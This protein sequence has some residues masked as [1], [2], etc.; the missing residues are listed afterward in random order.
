MKK[1]L[2]LILLF[3]ILISTTTGVHAGGAISTNV[4]ETR[5]TQTC[6]AESLIESLLAKANAFICKVKQEKRSL[7]NREGLLSDLY[8]IIGT[9]NFC[10]EIEIWKIM[11]IN[12]MLKGVKFNLFEIEVRL[13]Y[14]EQH[15]DEL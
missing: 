8:D 5:S 3:G 12:D 10:K 15:A 7:P 9:L 13:E 4:P 1:L 2:G 6:R 14:W 11:D